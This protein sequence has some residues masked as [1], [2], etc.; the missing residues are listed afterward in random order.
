[1]APDFQESDESGWS[2]SNSDSDPVFQ[3]DDEPR[4]PNG[5]PNGFSDGYNSD[6][7]REPPKTNGNGNLRVNGNGIGHQPVKISHKLNPDDRF[8]RTCTRLIRTPGTSKFPQ[9]SSKNVRR[10]FSWLW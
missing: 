10:I 7:D 5:L 9:F 1:M 4:I 8:L 2:D 3:S 6:D